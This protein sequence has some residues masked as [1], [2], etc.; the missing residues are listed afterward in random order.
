MEAHCRDRRRAGKPVPL[1]R[2]Y[3]PDITQVLAGIVDTIVM[4][5]AAFDLF[6]LF[7]IAFTVMFG[8]VFFPMFKH[9]I[10]G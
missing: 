7:C 3:S 4:I 10:F 2:Y 8:I 1:K 5:R 6:I 9:F